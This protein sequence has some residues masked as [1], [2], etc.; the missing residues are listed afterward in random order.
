M[1]HFFAYLVHPF[2]RKWKRKVEGC[3]HILTLSL[4]VKG[5]TACSWP[6]CATRTKWDSVYLGIFVVRPRSE[7]WQN[8]SFTC[9]CHE[10]I[11]RSG[12]MAVL[13]CNL[14]TRWRRVISF[15]TQPP[16][17]PGKS[18]WYPSHMGNWSLLENGTL[19][20]L[21]RESKQDFLVTQ[22][23]LLNP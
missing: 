8:T 1:Q 17:P 15:T 4:R 23:V 20:C 12:G 2:T 14:G 13:I 3:A 21:F 5:D 22:P 9:A 19:F 6:V 16:H 10:G 7:K 11:W 18:Y